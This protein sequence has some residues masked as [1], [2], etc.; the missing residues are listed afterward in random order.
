MR[1]IIH[2]FSLDQVVTRDT[3][4]HVSFGFLRLTQ[5]VLAVSVS[6]K[7]TLTGLR[8]WPMSH[9]D[10]ISR[11]ASPNGGSTT[12]SPPVTP[13]M[14][15]NSQPDWALIYA[16]AGQVARLR[17]TGEEAK[18]QPRQQPIGAPVCPIR[19]HSLATAMKAPFHTCC[20]GHTPADGLSV[21]YQVLTWAY[22]ILESGT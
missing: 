21:T 6:P 3:E 11:D 7:S 20:S 4:L 5:K 19:S 22:N 15:E 8:G 10:G 16:A 14:P 12:P 2:L 18:Q 13:F 9:S 1:D 17:L